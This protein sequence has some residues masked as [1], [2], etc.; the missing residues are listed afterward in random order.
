VCSLDGS[1][2]RRYESNKKKC[3]H[4]EFGKRRRREGRRG[5]ED[6]RRR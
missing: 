2:G 6:A 4:G 1:D 5:G 3:V